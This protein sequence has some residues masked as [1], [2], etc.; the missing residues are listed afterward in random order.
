CGIC[1]RRAISAIFTGSPTGCAA[2]SNKACSAYSAL[3]EIFMFILFS[4]REQ[5]IR[6]PRS[7]LRIFFIALIVYAVCPPFNSYDSYWTVPT[8]LSLLEHGTTAVDPF[9]PDSPEIS[10][11]ALQCVPE[12]G[13][14]QTNAQTHAQTN[15]QTCPNGH[16]YNF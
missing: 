6:L 7:D 10:H 13:P 16:W 14:A 2:K 12:N 1:C 11:Y 9:V 8:A 5:V 4:T 3:T 15:A